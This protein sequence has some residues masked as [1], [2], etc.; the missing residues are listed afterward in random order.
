MPKGI[1]LFGFAPK[2]TR[3]FGCFLF[4]SDSTGLAENSRVLFVLK[5]PG[6]SLEQ[7]STGLFAFWKLMSWFKQTRTG[8]SAFMLNSRTLFA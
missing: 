5:G 4:V 8:F 6:H 3:L 2:G 1:T 7:H